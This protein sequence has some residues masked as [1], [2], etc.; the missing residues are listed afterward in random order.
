MLL[1]L[2]MLMFGNAPE[3]VTVTV[4]VAVQPF[5]VLVAVTV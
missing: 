1:G 4:D 2:A 5:V 3:A